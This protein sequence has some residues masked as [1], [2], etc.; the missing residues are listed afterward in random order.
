MP[1]LYVRPGSPPSIGPGSRPHR[2][3]PT[4]SGRATFGP[5]QAAVAPPSILSGRSSHRPC[6]PGSRCATLGSCPQSHRSASVLLGSS[7]H[8]L[9]LTRAASSQPRP[10]FSR[11]G[12]ISAIRRAPSSRQ[13]GRTFSQGR[14]YLLYHHLGFLFGHLTRRAGQRLAQNRNRIVVPR[15]R[16]RMRWWEAPRQSVWP[17][18]PSTPCRSESPGTA[19]RCPSRSPGPAARSSAGRISER[20]VSGLGTISATARISPSSE[21]GRGPSRAEPSW[22]G[23]ATERC[24]HQ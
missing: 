16:I 18:G 14:P 8:H 19:P 22:T 15:L 1:L 4:G 11:Y 6:F 13:A 2:P 10:R 17:S 12:H 3:G 20:L 5:L 7:S 9:L 24:A 21:R 23:S